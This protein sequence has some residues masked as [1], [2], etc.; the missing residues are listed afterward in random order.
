MKC[1][2][3]CCSG[4]LKPSD[5]GKSPEGVFQ[6]SKCKSKFR[7]MK[8][9]GTLVTVTNLFTTRNEKPISVK[10]LKIKEK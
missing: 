2:F 4:I 8:D 5:N 10:E 9:T 7:K 1:R 3:D 6:C